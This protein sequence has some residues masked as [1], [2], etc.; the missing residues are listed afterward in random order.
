MSC[1][2]AFIDHRKTCFFRLKKQSRNLMRDI[3]KSL[4]YYCLPMSTYPIDKPQ[5]GK[6]CLAV[7]TTWK[8]TRKLPGCAM[9]LHMYEL[10]P[11][12][13]SFTLFF[14]TLELKG[15]VFP[16][17]ISVFSLKSSKW[18]RRKSRISLS[19]FQKSQRKEK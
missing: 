8:N 14:P 2:K 18:E 6:S 12:K 16:Q 13:L 4:H 11:E 17:L 10:Y 15:L 7:I 19:L 1:Y 5:K 9:S 3:V